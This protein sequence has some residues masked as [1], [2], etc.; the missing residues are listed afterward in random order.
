MGVQPGSFLLQVQRSCCFRRLA[1]EPTPELPPVQR[2]GPHGQAEAQLMRLQPDAAVPNR[3]RTM[4]VG[5]DG[6]VEG[7]LKKQVK[8][9]YSTFFR[10]V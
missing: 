8:K 2:Q 7:E 9:L 1:P 5:L 3:S 10:M 4:P 6:L